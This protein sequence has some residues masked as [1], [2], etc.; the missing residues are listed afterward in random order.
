[1]E[2]QEHSNLIE[3]V[4]F[5]TI[6]PS[7][8]SVSNYAQN[9]FSQ[10]TDFV[11]REYELEAI[12]QHFKNPNCRLLTLTGLGGIGK[13]RIA[14]EAATRITPMFAHGSY[15]VP[16]APIVSPNLV[17]PTLASAIG[18]YLHGDEPL[19][20]QLINYL[21]EREL[22]LVLDNF[23][24]LMS[25]IDLIIEI[26]QAA[27]Q[28]RLLVT[29]RERL[30]LH[31]EWVIDIYGMRYPQT[32]SDSSIEKYS[33]I[34]F[35]VEC[36]RRVKMDFELTETNKASVI[37]ICR[38]VEG[39][40]LGIEL[41]A[42]WVRVLS[43]QAIGD[44]IARSLDFLTSSLRNVPEK[45]GSMRAVFDQSYKLLTLEQQ[46]VFKKLSVFR[47][48]FRREATQAVAEASL[49][50]LVTLVDKSLLHTSGEDVYIMHE[51]L[52]QYAEEKLNASGDMEVT[53]SAHSAYYA[54]FISSRVK[55]LKGRRQIESLAEIK[56]DF[57]NVRTGWTWA[58]AHRQAQNIDNMLEGLWL[59]CNIR[60]REQ[61]S[62]TL[63]Q[64]AEQAFSTGSQ[65]ERLR[66]RLLARSKGTEQKQLEQVLQIARLYND[67][68]EIA[69]CLQQLSDIFREQGDQAKADQ[70]LEQSLDHYRRSGDRYGEADTLFRIMSSLMHL[71]YDGILDD[72]KRYGEE[73]LRLRREIGDQVGIAWSIAPV[74]H[75]LAR[76]G[77]F[78][79]AEGLWWERIRLG[80]E[81]G[82]PSLIALGYAHISYQIYFPQGDFV[83]A[84]MTAEEGIKIGTETNILSSVGFGLMTLGLIA[85]MEENYQEA[86][87][88]CQQATATTSLAWVVGMAA[89]GSTIA[90]CGLEDYQTVNKFFS[91]AF[92]Y[93]LHMFARVG[94]V[95]CLPIA[96]ILLLQK[97]DQVRAVELLALAFTHPVRASGWMEKWPLLARLRLQ[98]EQKLGDK[99][100]AAAWER[101]M[102]L[103]VDEVAA[104]LMQ[105]F[106]KKQLLSTGKTAPSS[107]ISLSERELEVLQ[108]VAKGSSNQEIADQLVIGVSTV[109]KHINHIYDK[110]DAKNRTQAVAI[111]RERQLLIG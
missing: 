73:S 26:L 99:E 49:T 12:E 63:F 33:A 48:G 13:T 7:I 55:D 62:S 69:L 36:A 93:R 53:Q 77:H 67:N 101:G 100:Y 108:L 25:D 87:Q 37:R 56:A 23:E 110:L 89:W 72:F 91:I 27:P 105:Q 35:F 3:P 4:S 70:L 104:E 78:A 30:N 1:M 16:L 103:D 111:A 46:Q 40:P 92:D 2:N 57:E 60:N 97:G 82:A 98:L 102:R 29:S 47:G 8:Q 21:S 58:A 66:V 6:I 86:E 11:G 17:A 45:H 74:A 15:F 75:S 28:V 19:R 50:T 41:A 20:T 107:M 39:V 44:E 24:Q 88:L 65:F 64:M 83:R 52:R 38:L 76:D 34:Q 42:S 5:G 68:V 18:L 96:A 32:E 14:Y 90:A 31:E 84:R 79:P 10:Q 106:P 71:S 95:G 94:I 54:A 80:Q 85:S 61:E 51:L 43:C 81:V 109:K 59:F 9:I 22:L